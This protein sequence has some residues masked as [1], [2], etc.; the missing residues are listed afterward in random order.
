ML[1]IPL[2]ISYLFHSQGLVVHFARSLTEPAEAVFKIIQKFES[3]MVDVDKFVQTMQ[4]MYLHWRILRERSMTM[5]QLQ[6]SYSKRPD[7]CPTEQLQAA[8]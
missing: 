8:I 4:T 3:L 5:G 7:V 1:E 2:R 6:G